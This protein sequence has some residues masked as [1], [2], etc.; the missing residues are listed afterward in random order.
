MNKVVHCITTIER[1]GAENQLLILVREQIRSGNK[2]YIVYLKGKPELEREFLDIG[3]EVID[4]LLNKNILIQVY[5]LFKYIRSENFILHAHLPRAELISFLCNTGSKLI[6]TRHNAEPF[7][8]RGPKLISKLLSRIITSRSNRCIAISYAVKDYIIRNKEINKK[9]QIDVVYYGFDNTYLKIS[10]PQKHH[11]KFVIGSIGRLT[12]Q[13]DQSTLLR[14]F[15]QYTKH[16]KA[17]QLL[18]VGDGEL[19]QELQSLSKELGVFNKIV[20]VGKVP[21][22]Y[23]YL[24]IMD[25]FILPSIYEGFGMV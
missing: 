2:V 10:S 24:S 1:G 5:L 14:S 15:A 16:N 19:K 21:N 25:V 7:Y 6:I 13:K 12:H 11:E 22:V 17:A 9:N 20:W 4:I 23:E 3:A 18:L 8:P